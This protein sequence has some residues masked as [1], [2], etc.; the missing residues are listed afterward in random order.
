MFEL[1]VPATDAPSAARASAGAVR[2]FNWQYAPFL[3]LCHLIAVLAFFPWF[4]SWTAVVLCVLGCY[5]FGTLGIAVCFHRLLT[6][7]SFAC[8]LWLEHT[9]SILGVCTV[10][11]SPAY[12][13]AIHRRHHHFSDDAD[14]PHSPRETFF[15][16]HVG[17]LTVKRGD[18]QPVP[19]IERYAMDL[20]RDPFQQRLEE[21][22]NWAKIVLA[23][24]VAFFALG[25]GIATLSGASAADATQLGLSV[26][27]WLG[28]VRI[29]FGWHTAWAVNSVCHLWGYR[30]YDTRDLSRNNAIVGWLASGEGWHNNHHAD[31]NSA[32]HGH[33]WWEFDLAWLTIRLFEA[34][35]LAWDVKRPSLQPA[36]QRQPSN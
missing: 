23:S 12:W 5:V 32:R 1:G 20:W 29:L 36:S 17:W 19:L 4:F 21:S 34:V 15:W 28:A 33:A 14:D 6:H 7:R 22:D 30:S 16:A 27:V 26:L 13:V 35:G 9:L 3:L 24:W 31:P 8:P 18:M 10:Q 2:R 25:F 11:D